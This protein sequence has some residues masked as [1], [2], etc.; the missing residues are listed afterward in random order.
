MIVNGNREEEEQKRQQAALIQSNITNYFSVERVSQMVDQMLRDS[1]IQK[2]QTIERQQAVLGL[3]TAGTVK[4]INGLKGTSAAGTLVVSGFVLE[5]ARDGLGR[6]LMLGSRASGPLAAVALA[7]GPTRMGDATLS[8]AKEDAKNNG[9]IMHHYSPYSVLHG[10]TLRPNSYLTPYFGY[11]SN[12]AIKNLALRYDPN[13]T[14]LYIHSFKVYEGQYRAAENSL[15]G[16]NIVAPA[17]NQPGGGIEFIS[18]TTLVPLGESM[19][20]P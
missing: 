9:T 20:A 4:E 18:N 19:P 11:T 3:S 8:G 7:L 15:P 10:G 13:N 5:G 14:Q 12:G 6:L 17:N 1:Q 16:T 2:L